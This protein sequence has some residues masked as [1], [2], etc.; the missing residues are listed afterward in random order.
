MKS[1][2]ILT[3]AEHHI[4]PLKKKKGS[5]FMIKCQILDHY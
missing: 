1:D 5:Q 3:E 2:T 4:M